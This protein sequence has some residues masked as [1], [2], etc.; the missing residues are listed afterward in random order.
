MRRY[1]LIDPGFLQFLALH[2]IVHCGQQS[3]AAEPYKKA[4]ENAAEKNNNEHGITS[5]RA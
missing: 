5:C 3:H 4:Q 2:A 1:T